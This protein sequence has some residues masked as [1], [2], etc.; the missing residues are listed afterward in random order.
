VILKVI[1]SQNTHLSS[2]HSAGAANWA[3]SYREPSLKLDSPGSRRPWHD[4]DFHVL[5]FGCLGDGVA[6]SYL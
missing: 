6:S 4:K 5:C 2:F 1:R 3:P